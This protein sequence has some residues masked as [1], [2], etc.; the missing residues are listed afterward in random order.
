MGSKSETYY[1]RV[2]CYVTVLWG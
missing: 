1:I 2:E